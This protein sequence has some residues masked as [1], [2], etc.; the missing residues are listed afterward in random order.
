VTEEQHEQKKFHRKLPC[1]NHPFVAAVARCEICGK[2]ICRSCI[3]YYGGEYICSSACWSTRLMKES[4]EIIHRQGRRRRREILAFAIAGFV[5]FACAAWIISIFFLYPVFVNR[6]GTR[7]WTIAYTP[8]CF[9]FAMG[10][11]SDGAFFLL[12]GDGL[13][14]A[15]DLFSGKERWSARLPGRHEHCKAVAVDADRVSIHFSNKI[16]LMRSDRTKPVWEYTSQQPH[17][18][19]GPVYANETFF[20]ASSSKETSSN[21]GS[22]A[23]K[24]QITDVAAV[25]AST[26][27]Q[28]WN[29]SLQGFFADAILTDAHTLYVLGQASGSVR[30]IASDSLQVS[31]HVLQNEN[32]S[33]S[34]SHLFAL[35]AVTGEVKWQAVLEGQ[36]ARGPFV[37][38]EGI[39]IATRD[40]IYLVSRA[41]EIIWRY[42]LAEQVVCNIAL[43]DRLLFVQTEDGML[44]CI[45]GASGR[46]KWMC[47]AGLKADRLLVE[48][49]NIYLC[50]DKLGSCS[51]EIPSNELSLKGKA[52]ADAS[53][54]KTFYGID[55]ESGRRYFS[56]TIPGKSAFSHGVLYSL[57]TIGENPN[58]SLSVKPG[59]SGLVSALCAYRCLTG[60]KTWEIPFE[61]TACDL[62][63]ANDIAIIKV[64][65][66]AEPDTSNSGA[67]QLLGIR[68]K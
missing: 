16:V 52:P 47:K 63:M 13:L 35:N 30:P 61:G 3:G 64:Q 66:E 55:I 14:Q 62:V 48:P 28:L 22:E 25:E 1:S 20:C 42:P 33:A 12:H 7:I 6:A 39:V 18:S 37:R 19:A 10:G 60:E 53:P 40:F 54:E 49:P 32:D 15:V 31:S 27:S 4:N 41:G 21:V 2:L 45:D 5:G 51:T 26:G 67:V 29:V 59:K 57:S 58:N 34:V 65:K 24:E 43:S 8:S 56:R 36:Y 23:G 50:G 46:R 68:I 44:A 17:L 9:G 11:P 38:P